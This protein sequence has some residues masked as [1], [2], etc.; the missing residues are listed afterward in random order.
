MGTETQSALR[1]HDQFDKR[2]PPEIWQRTFNRLY[3]SQLSRISMVNK[4]FNTIVSSL[5]V[6]SHMFSVAFGPKMRLRTLRNIPESK[7]YML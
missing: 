5:P 4:N 1:T 6:W 2:V 3:P 7:S